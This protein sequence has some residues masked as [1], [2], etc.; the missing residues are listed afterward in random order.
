[1]NDMNKCSVAAKMSKRLIA[2][3]EMLKG[4]SD[5]GSRKVADVGCDHGYIS[6]YLVQSGI[7]GKAFAMDVRKGPL[8][9]AS[10]NIREYG[11]SD[12]IETRLSDGFKALLPEEADSAIVAG[13][14]GKLMIRILEEGD[15]VRLGI[16]EAILQPQ[17]D[18]D[19]FRRYLRGEGFVIT[20][21]KI[22]LDEGKYYF[23]MKV[24]FED[25][26][27][28]SDRLGRIHDYLEEAVSLLT[29]KT[30]CSKEEAIRICDR[31]GEH[32]ILRK[33][34]LLQSFCQHGKEVTQSILKELDKS[35]HLD[36]HQELSQDLAE[37]E[38]V[39]KLYN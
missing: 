17:S 4:D 22:I 19:E 2:I 36:R 25:T 15:P 5:T 10:D 31:F 28:T 12:R 21:E 34:E 23:P 13:M 8:S 29:E 32:N 33:E 1:M 18:L 26:N 7:A 27:R 11:L 14:G 6:I 35:G 37:L 16:K 24:S 9:G 20:D 38:C 30:N 39:L 3:A